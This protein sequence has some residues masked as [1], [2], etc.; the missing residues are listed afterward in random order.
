M[1]QAMLNYD[2]IKNFPTSRNGKMA[3]GILCAFIARGL[4]TT[5]HDLMETNADGALMA[6]LAAGLMVYVTV[7]AVIR[8][9]TGRP[10]F[11]GRG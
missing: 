9:D 8:F 5:G 4:I 11:E 3:F 2:H 6:F 7:L 1:E 10:L